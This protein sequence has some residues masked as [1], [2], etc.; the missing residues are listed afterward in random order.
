MP[1]VRL[2]PAPLNR[3]LHFSRSSWHTVK[4]RR[5]TLQPAQRTGLSDIMKAGSCR[6]SSMASSLSSVQDGCE[7]A[8]WG[9]LVREP[10]HREAASGIPYGPW[11]PGVSSLLQ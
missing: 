4:R 3:K 2:T 7:W 1:S 6:V 9:V 10:Q 8:A 11:G 5:T